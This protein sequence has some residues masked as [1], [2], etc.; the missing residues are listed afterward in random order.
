MAVYL[1]PFTY[2][3]NYMLCS[4]TGV[5]QPSK[6]QENGNY[7]LYYFLLLK[8]NLSLWLKE[9]KQDKSPLLFYFVF[10]LSTLMQRINNINLSG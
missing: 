8:F 10:S 7:P 9:I 3:S 4:K 5:F 6:S 2:F 1:C